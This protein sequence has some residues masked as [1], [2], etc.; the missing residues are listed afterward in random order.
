MHYKIAM[1]CQSGEQ[2][3]LISFAYETYT[4]ISHANTEDRLLRISGTYHL[5]NLQRIQNKFLDGE[6]K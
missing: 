6:F 3:C 1:Y 5:T 2:L 4:W